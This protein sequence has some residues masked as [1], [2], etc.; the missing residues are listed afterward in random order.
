MWRTLAVALIGMA[1]AS[2]APAQQVGDYSRG[3]LLPDYTTRL[4]ASDLARRLGL[5]CDVS[6]VQMRGRTESGTA[7]YE[8]IC[9]Q[10][11]GYILI[12]AP[13]ERAV[14]CAA[15][16]A[17]PPESA[18]RLPGAANVTSAVRRYAVTAGLTCQ[19]D[20][21]RLVGLSTSGG[22]IYEAGCLGQSGAWLT[23]GPGGWEPLD[24]LRVEARGDSCRLTTEAE[25]VRTLSESVTAQACAPQ[26][27]RYMGESN[28]DSLIEISCLTGA[29]YVVRLGPEGAL[30]EAIPCARATMIGD[31]CR[32]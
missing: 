26:T 28:Y 11:G 29:G 14:D 9:R 27:Y 32:L 24:C 15:L 8:V 6:Q 19:V 20:G 25:R 31:G 21:G 13:D 5:S 22:R 30:R 3:G 12:G 7:I 23:E 1:T 10:G 18:C 4:S 2:T 16:E 17:G